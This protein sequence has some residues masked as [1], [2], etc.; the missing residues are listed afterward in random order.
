[1]SGCER[2]EL[3]RGLE[4]RAATVRGTLYDLPA[5]YP[6]LVLTGAGRVHG[7]LVDPP[8]ARLLGVLDVYEG[9]S[10]GLYDRIAVDVKVGLRTMRAWTYALDGHR[11][12]S[13]RLIPDGRWRAPRH[14]DTL[15]S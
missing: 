14:R 12:R 4:R 3:L 7:E 15:R 2:A 8:D 5:G 6:A 11:A 10:E 13:G 1:M 9:V